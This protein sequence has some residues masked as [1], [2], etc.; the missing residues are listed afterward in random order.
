LGNEVKEGENLPSLGE[1]RLVTID[2]Q[3]VAVFNV[4]GHLFAV[5]NKCPHRQGPL[6]RGRVESTPAG[7]A[8]RCPIHGWLFDLKTGRCLNQPQVS[9]PVYSITCENGEGV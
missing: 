8:V 7:P 4:E 5:G 9:T 3:E 2:G 6:A 1:S